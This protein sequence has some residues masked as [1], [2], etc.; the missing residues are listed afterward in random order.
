[1]RSFDEI[2]ADVRPAMNEGDAAALTGLVVELEE[3]D[4]RE[5][6][7]WELLIQATLKRRLNQMESA[8][9]SYE[10]ALNAFTQLD[11]VD[12]L[13]SSLNGLGLCASAVGRR[14]EAIEH[15][16]RALAVYRKAGDEQGEARSLTNLAVVYRAKGDHAAAVTTADEALHMFI[17]LEHPRGQMSALVERSR[18]FAEEGSAEKALEQLHQAREV[19]EENDVRGALHMVY[20]NLGTIHFERGE[21]AKAL[22]WYHKSLEDSE[23]IGDQARIGGDLANLGMLVG[24][25]GQYP[26]AL[27]YFHRA[28]SAFEVVGSPR[29]EEHV[30]G[31]LGVLYYRMG[32]YDEAERH[33]RLA[34]ERGQASSNTRS[35]ATSL[36]NMGEVKSAVGEYDEAIEFYQQARGMFDEGGQAYMQLQVDVSLADV[37][38]K[39]GDLDQAREVVQRLGD[40]RAMSYDIDHK[41]LVLLGRYALI[42]GDV[43]E[44]HRWFGEALDLAEDKAL[45]HEQAAAHTQLRDLAEATNDLKAYIAH[46]KK[47]QEITELI[48]GR[49]ASVRLAMVTKEREIRE[50]REQREKERTLLYSALPGAIADRLIEGESVDDHYAHAVVLF[51]DIVGFTSHTSSMEPNNV[52]QFL[53]NLYQSFDDICK[54]HDV[55]KVKTIGDSYL[56]FKGDGTPEENARA[57]AKVAAAILQLDV[58]WPDGESLLMRIGVH[59]GP[60]SAGVIGTERLQYDIWGDTVN[61]ASRM[62]STGEPGK[63]QASEEFAQSCERSEQ[64]PTTAFTKRGEI[65]IKG[66]GAMTTYWLEGA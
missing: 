42:T 59:A 8:L 10:L 66:K 32:E 49:E 65:D 14:D 1:M 3:Y 6:R 22:E 11:D 37:F 41:R 57:I 2:R 54:Q 28:L 58:A 9:Q 23:Q 64:D 30:Y 35:I 51:C 63:I 43:E 17:K 50:E 52:I 55:M 18:L 34:I 27:E 44:A 48:A 15:H 36:V 12:G 21:H 60:V 5:A 62:E 46:N 39:K 4:T 26:E 13:G 47:H 40:A 31:N 24:S 56:C 19:G 25:M 20:N 29:G 53:E 38:L 61:T 7:A 33:N 16:R 45:L